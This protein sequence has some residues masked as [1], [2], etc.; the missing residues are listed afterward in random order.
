M[1]HRFVF[2]ALAALLAVSTASAKEPVRLD[3]S[4]DAAAEASWKAMHQEASP[5]QKRELPLAMLKI[6][7]A[8]T[9]SA[10]D[11]VGDPELQSLGIARIK[12]KVAGMTADEIIALGNR[13]STIK[14]EPATE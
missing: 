3:A 2:A 14:A 8:G 13:V 11:V 6:N 5:E 9:K 10:Y 4:S 12:D 1:K 7:L